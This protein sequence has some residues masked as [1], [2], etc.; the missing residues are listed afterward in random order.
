M[1]QVTCPVEATQAE[2]TA[3]ETINNRNDIS[4]SDEQEMHETDNMPRES[5]SKKQLL[6][7]D[8][9]HVKK[10]LIQLEIIIFILE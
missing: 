4:S 10:N 3:D 2:S 6:K 8:V 9:P 7:K 1:Q 5:Q